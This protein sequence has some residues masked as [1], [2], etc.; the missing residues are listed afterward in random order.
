MYGGES[1]MLMAVDKKRI[2]SFEMTAYRRMMS[3][4]WK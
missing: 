1:W 4:S 3:V 2:T